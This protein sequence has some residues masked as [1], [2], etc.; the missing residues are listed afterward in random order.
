MVLATSG[1][2]SVLNG[3]HELETKGFKRL[4]VVIRLLFLRIQ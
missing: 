2:K 3:Q 1:G 4:P